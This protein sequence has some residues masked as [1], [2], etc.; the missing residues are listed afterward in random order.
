M[1]IVTDKYAS[2]MKH[3]IVR[4]HIAKNMD[5]IT[6]E[7]SN[8]RQNKISLYSI[9]LVADDLDTFCFSLRYRAGALHGFAVVVSED[10]APGR[11]LSLIGITA[12]RQKLKPP[13]LKVGFRDTHFHSAGSDLQRD[14]LVQLSRITSPS[15]RVSLRGALRLPDDMDIHSITRAMGPS[16]VSYQALAWH[17]LA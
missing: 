11:Q 16:L 12:S 3:H 14:L 2:R 8:E 9:L 13:T 17:F 10:Q 15:L 5:R 6:A 1:P 7:V 4:L